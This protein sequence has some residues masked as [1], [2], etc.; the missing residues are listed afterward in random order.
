MSKK[1]ALSASPSP[2][3][4]L[5]VQHRNKVPKTDILQGR[6]L[7]PVYHLNGDILN[8]VFDRLPIA[9]AFSCAS[10]NKAWEAVAL[11]WMH[12]TRSLVGQKLRSMCYE[13][14]PV[15]LWQGLSIAE[16]KYYG[17]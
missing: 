8:M 17:G 6:L 10:L 4:E 5:D 7:D 9:D 2:T 14:V 16:I 13:A 3:P 11:R 15:S 1:R 12:Q